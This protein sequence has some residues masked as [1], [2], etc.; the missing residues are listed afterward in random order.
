MRAW[1]RFSTMG[2]TA[3]V[4]TVLSLALGGVAMALPARSIDIDY[5]SDATFTEIVGGRVLTCSG[6]GG[7]WGE[8]TDYA[9]DYGE[10][11]N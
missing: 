11:C 1:S 7:R 4:G 8:R 10:S 5:Y 6:N 9:I 2:K 3:V